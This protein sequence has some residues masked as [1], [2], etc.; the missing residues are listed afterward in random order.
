MKI[1]RFKWRYLLVAVG[2]LLVLN[3]CNTELILEDQIINK[4][5]ISNTE[6]RAT[7][8]KVC[9]YAKSDDFWNVISISSNALSAHLQHGDVQL[10][11]SDG[12]GYVEQINECVPGGDCDDTNA[13]INPGA[14]EICD[15]IDNN[16]D[17]NI[18][19]GFDADA[20]GF[21]TCQGDCDDTDATIYPG[22]VEICNN[23]VDE[24]CN[25]QA[26]EDCTD[27]ISYWRFNDNLTDE[28][29]TNDGTGT[30]ITYIAGKSGNAVD[31]TTGTSSKV[32]VADAAELSFGDGSTDS[33]FSISMYVYFNSL[34]DGMVFDKRTVGGG[35]REYS[36]WWDSGPN[37]LVFRLFDQSTGGY[38]QYKHAWT[39]STA[40]W[41][42]L[43]FT[44]SGSGISSGMVIYLDGLAVGSPTSSGSYTAME[45]G[46]G[47]LVIGKQ[48]S[49]TTFSVDGY[50]D[51]FGLWSK[52]LTSDEVT[53]IYDTQNGGTEIL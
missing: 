7:K 49:G 28:V 18:D 8:I 26:D 47:S 23:G 27:L 48:A 37:M 20:D 16:C 12:D 44:Y 30:A 46:T 32:D 31:L 29:S 25:G 35:A 38:I 53:S 36:G 4:N 52:E 11:D 15:G 19:E 2:L 13:A 3:S 10:I 33:P 24:N 22:A 40:T 1:I 41:Y 17:R 9:H 45:N 50:I 34:T 51:G 6:I 21:T 39:P 42:H 14:T 5:D 43:T